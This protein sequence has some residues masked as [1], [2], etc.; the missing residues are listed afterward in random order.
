MKIIIATDGSEFSR[1]ANEKCCLLPGKKSNLEIKIVSAY[2]AYIP[3][4]NHPQSVQYV[5]T[6]AREM[7]KQA[8]GYVDE[9]AT[10]I[11]KVLPD[12][13]IDLTT[14]VKV[15]ATDRVIIET[16]EE[17]QADL[18]VVGSHGRGFWGRALLGS[19]SDAVIHHAPCSVLVVRKKQEADF[20][21]H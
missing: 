17:W 15:G 7:H 13:D 5:E 3:L 4:D 16:A 20:E 2:Q 18:I 12:A 14:L 1:A 19:V 10:V 11:R 21:D 9:A 8:E 6:F